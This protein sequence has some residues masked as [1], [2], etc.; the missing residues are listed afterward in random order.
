MIRR[1]SG[2]ANKMGR[3]EMRNVV[4]RLM[5][6][7]NVR[8]AKVAGAQEFVVS[9]CT[10]LLETIV[11][12]RPMSFNQVSLI[13]GSGRKRTPRETKDGR[14]KLEGDIRPFKRITSS[15]SVEIARKLGRKTCKQCCSICAA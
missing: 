12:D 9:I 13:V 1:R 3:T 6:L 11:P 2:C 10:G 15:L 7:V 8:T 4:V 14:G 5:L